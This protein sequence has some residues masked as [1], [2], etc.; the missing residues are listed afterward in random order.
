EPA[1][2]DTGGTAGSMRV[3]FLLPHYGWH[4]SGGFRVVYTYAG[5]LAE[6]GH[7][8]SVVHPRRLPAGGWQRPR[9]VLQHA[10]RAATRVRDIVL[11]PRLG[12]VEID[13]RVRLL[14]APA[15]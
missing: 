7:E 2:R 6:R 10:R 3:T 8:V 5:L 4:A 9:G 12:W 11:R 15:I 14:Y 13:P 1:T